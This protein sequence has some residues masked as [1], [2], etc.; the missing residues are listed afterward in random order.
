MVYTLE[1]G[2]YIWLGSLG[3]T[4]ILF[5]YMDPEGNWDAGGSVRFS[6]HCLRDLG[7]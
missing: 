2:S 6:T 4:Y 7:P 5:R 1:M 3:S